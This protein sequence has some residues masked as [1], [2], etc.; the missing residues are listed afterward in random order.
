MS[1]LHL[2]TGYAGE[3]HITSADQGSFNAALFGNGEF[4]LERGNQ[5]AASI[6]TNNQ[7]RVL[8]G[9][10]LMQGRHIRM[11][12]NTFADLYFDN[13]TQGYKRIDL[14]VARYTK[15]ATT[16]IESAELVVIKGTPSESDAVAPEHVTGDIINEQALQNDVVLY[17]VHF[18]GIN[19]QELVKVFSTVETLET[20][21]KQL[22]SDVENKLKDVEIPI[23]SDT[24]EM[25][26]I[27]KYGKYVADAKTV[28]EIAAAFQ[29]GC[30]TLVSG[31]TTYGATPSSNSPA[32]IVKAISNIYTNRYNAGIN[33]VI[34]NP[35]SYG[36]SRVA[37]ISGSANLN[38]VPDGVF[39]VC[40]IN[41]KPAFH[42][43]D[44]VRGIS[45]RV[46]GYNGDANQP[47]GPTISG[48]YVSC[49][50]NGIAYKY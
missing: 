28:G 2:V 46:Y 23:I 13:G 22:I 48:T 8:D 43:I 16:D 9:D 11:N 6:I 1:N 26:L 47:S 12:E 20:L 35:T 15:D 41:G 40:E 5:F 49:C 18:Y 38:F 50:G 44:N 33:A 14:I 17:Q 25:K 37:F 45:Q 3:A 42:W 4:V 24:E 29:D 31:C 39:A 27:E 32:D 36:L 30:N 34:N 10:L 7:V 21:K 19:M